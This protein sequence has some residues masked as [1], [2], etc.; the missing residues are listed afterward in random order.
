[1]G[2][3]EIEFCSLSSGSSGNCYYIGKGRQGILI[4]AGIPA[5]KVRRYLKDL[6][7]SMP[8]IMG[9][10]ISH[11]HTDHTRGLEL[12]TRKNHIPVYTTHRVWESILTRKINVSGA[13]VNKVE[14]QRSFHLAGFRIQ[15]FPLSHDAPETLGFHICAGEARVT[16]ATDLGHISQTAAGYIRAARLLVIESKYD[17]RMLME[18]SYP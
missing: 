2:T 7:I 12:L 6:G 17:E 18:G 1:M 10:L 11:N 9:V 16:I 3:E 14:L 5:G 4:D 15:V 8:S 13:S